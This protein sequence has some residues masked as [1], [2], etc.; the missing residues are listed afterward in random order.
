[1]E[2]EEA[3]SYINLGNCILFVALVFLWGLQIQVTQ[4]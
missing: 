1:M 3:L 2:F 4:R